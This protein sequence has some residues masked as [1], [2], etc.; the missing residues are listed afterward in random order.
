MGCSQI[1]Q[2]ANREGIT[3]KMKT[4]PDH[5]ISHPNANQEAEHLREI[6]SLTEKLRIAEQAKELLWQANIALAN[7]LNAKPPIS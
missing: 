4:D 6:E 2:S 7:R 3:F 5:H 1:E